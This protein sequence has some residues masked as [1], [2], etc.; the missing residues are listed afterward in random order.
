VPFCCV[1]LPIVDARTSTPPEDQASAACLPTATTSTSA[2]SASRGYHLLGAHT[3]LF[4]SRNIRTITT[5]QLRGI[6]TRRLLPSASTLVSSCVVPPL[7]L[8]GDVRLCVC[9]CVWAAPLLGY[10]PI[11]VRIESIYCNPFS[12]QYNNHFTLL[13]LG[14]RAFCCCYSHT[15]TIGGLMQIPGLKGRSGKDSIQ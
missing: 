12:M 2:T 1:A 11:R 8:R 6:S 4:S 14:C 3:G 7:Q 5:L 10:R 9:E 13:Q 15:L